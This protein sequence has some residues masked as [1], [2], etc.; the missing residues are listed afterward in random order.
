MHAYISR[1]PYIVSCSQNCNERYLGRLKD[2]RFCFIIS[3]SGYEVTT[4]ASTT[5]CIT[6]SASSLCAGLR[7]AGCSLL[8]SAT[9]A[10]RQSAWLLGAGMP[11]VWQLGARLYGLH[12]YPPGGVEELLHPQQ[13]HSPA[14][15]SRAHCPR[16]ASTSE[17]AHTGGLHGQ[18]GQW[19]LSAAPR[20]SGGPPAAG[21]ANIC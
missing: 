16:D 12:L 20:V 2:C 14:P 1:S 11:S 8:L 5:K 4:H 21:R 6:I 9:S 3:F 17:Q 13:C 19:R 15:P 10:D 18:R 7:P